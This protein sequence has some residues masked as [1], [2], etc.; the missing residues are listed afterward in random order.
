MELQIYLWGDPG[1][2]GTYQAAIRRAGGEPLLSRDVGAASGCAGLLLPGGGDVAPWRYGQRNLASRS[3]EPE[4]DA[5]EWALLMQFAAAG[6]PVLGICRGMQSINVFFGGTLLQDLPGHA[7]ASRADRLHKVRS[8]PS[9]LWELWGETCITNS[10]HH[11]AV[12]HLGHDLQAVQWAPDGTVEALLH[13]ALPIWAVQWHPERLCGPLA[14]AG[15]ADGGRLFGA[16]LQLC[17]Q[18]GELVKN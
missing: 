3:I 10:A 7:A 18:T 13:R 6:K 2:Y 14:K 16:W 5:A 12:D 1:Q 11:Q 17:A 8:A 4:R 15:A 9:P